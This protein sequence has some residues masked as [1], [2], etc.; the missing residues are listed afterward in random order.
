[1]IGNIDSTGF[2]KRKTFLEQEILELFPQTDRSI[3][4][5]QPWER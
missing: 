1:M 2:S 3:K 4:R 5:I